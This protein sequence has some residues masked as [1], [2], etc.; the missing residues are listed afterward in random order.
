MPFVF[1]GNQWYQRLQDQ[2]TINIPSLSFNK[3]SL[4]MPWSHSGTTNCFLASVYKPGSDVLTGHSLDAS[5]ITR[6][7]DC[8]S[9]SPPKITKTRSTF[10]CQWERIYIHDTK[11]VSMYCHSKLRLL[12]LVSKRN[13]GHFGTTP[14]QSTSSCCLTTASLV[15]W[16]WKIC[17]PE[18]NWPRD[19][20]EIY[21]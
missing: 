3:R 7:E 6:Y 19:C 17:P 12:Y 8:R 21:Y 9:T 18:L 14:F 16:F 1:H 20:Q 2:A 15:L 13:F 11:Q 10:G 5:Y 4:L